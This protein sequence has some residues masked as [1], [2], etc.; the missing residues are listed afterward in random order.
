MLLSGEVSADCLIIHFFRQ[1]FIALPNSDESDYFSNKV[2]DLGLKFYAKGICSSNTQTSQTRLMS[3][4]VM[5]LL[6]CAANLLLVSATI[7]W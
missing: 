3:A 2:C 5:C 7:V 1:T 6:S 4:K